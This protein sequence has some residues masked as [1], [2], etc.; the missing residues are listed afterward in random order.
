MLWA[1]CPQ[2]YRPLFESIAKNYPASG[3]ISPV[4]AAEQLGRLLHG[5][6]RMLGVDRKQALAAGFPALHEVASECQWSVIPLALLPVLRSSRT[7]ARIPLQCAEVSSASR[8]AGHSH[9]LAHV[10]LVLCQIGDVRLLKICSVSCRLWTASSWIWLRSKT[11]SSCPHSPSA[12]GCRR[13]L[14]T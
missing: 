6:N 13:L 12:E 14:L 8:V 11:M 3:M 4:Y 7:K 2:Q 9:I 5:Q 10:V 1:R